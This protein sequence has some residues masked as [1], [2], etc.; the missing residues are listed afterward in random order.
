MSKS[1]LLQANRRV[2]LHSSQADRRLTCLSSKVAG[3]ISI[4]T[5]PV[6]MLMEVCRE[7]CTCE[8][9]RCV[10][11]GRRR[12]RAHLDQTQQYI[13][14]RAHYI[15]FLCRLSAMCLQ[16]RSSRRQTFLLWRLALVQG[17]RK[18]SWKLFSKSVWLS[19]LR[20]AML[21]FP[22]QHI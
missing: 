4:V 11:A 10:D 16:P 9:Q 17:P 19:R 5:V 8:L 13:I 1:V 20:R 7:I 21:L 2:V 12:A 6:A 15:L 22:H 18:E 14:L 3:A